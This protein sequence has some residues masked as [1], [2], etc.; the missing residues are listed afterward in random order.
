[1]LHSRIQSSSI[2]AHL[3]P[4]IPAL[5]HRAMHLPYRPKIA[6]RKTIKSVMTAVSSHSLVQEWVL[7]F[8][9]ATFSLCADYGTL[10][11]KVQLHCP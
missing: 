1:M 11:L 2:Q 6:M 4:C 8:V 3:Q 7:D 10:T 9:A 5:A